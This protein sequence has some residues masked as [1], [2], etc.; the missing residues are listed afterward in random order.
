MALLALVTLM[1]GQLGSEPRLGSVREVLKTKSVLVQLREIGP[2]IWDRWRL[3]SDSAPGQGGGGDGEGIANRKRGRT[4]R[5]QVG[6]RSLRKEPLFS[7]V[8]LA[9]HTLATP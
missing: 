9:R 1:P 3:P 2:R 6:I 4:R 8:R 7:D 5:V